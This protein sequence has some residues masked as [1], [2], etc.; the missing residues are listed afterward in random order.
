M[1]ILLTLEQLGYTNG[2]DY[3]VHPDDPFSIAVWKHADPQPDQAT[4]DA[5]WAT[6]A[7]SL[8]TPSLDDIKLIAK[9]T[10]D[11]FAGKVRQRFITTGSGQEMIY[12]RKEDQAEAF[13]AAGYP[14]GNLSDYPLIEAEAIATDDTGQQATD[15]ILAQRDLWLSAGATIERVRREGKNT[16]DQQLSEAGVDVAKNAT[17][18]ALDA[19]T[20]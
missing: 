8:P 20:P 3:E 15:A 5:A 19:I 6:V 11:M 13:K 1:N 12:L 10:V 17:L 16:I 18:A 14:E 9:Y 7:A 2:T 4:L